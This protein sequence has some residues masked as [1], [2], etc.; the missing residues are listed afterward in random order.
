MLYEVITRIF[1]PFFTTK[2]VGKGTGQGLAIAHAL[3][4]ER[5]GGEILLEDR[6]GGGSIFTVLLPVRGPGRGAPAA[7]T[8]GLS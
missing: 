1:E 7:E 3:V 2:P 4:V 8:K 5:Y 6:P